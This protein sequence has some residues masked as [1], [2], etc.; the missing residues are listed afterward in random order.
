MTT[1]RK[2]KNIYNCI[3]VYMAKSS[4]VRWLL[5][6]EVSA[7]SGTVYTEPSGATATTEKGIYSDRSTVLYRVIAPAPA[8]TVVQYVVVC[9]GKT[10]K[11]YETI[12]IKR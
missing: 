1:E 3:V 7:K 12:I 10:R 9:N 2:G 4:A 11:N 8:C 6:T 5:G